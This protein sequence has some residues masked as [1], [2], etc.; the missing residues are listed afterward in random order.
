MVSHY[1]FQELQTNIPTPTK[2]SLI[3]TLQLLLKLQEVQVQ[4]QMRL[5]NKSQLTQVKVLKQDLATTPRYAKIS[6]YSLLF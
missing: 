5:H 1:P 4:N 6:I 2:T 3:K